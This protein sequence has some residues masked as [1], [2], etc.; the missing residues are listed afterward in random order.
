MFYSP[1]STS[2]MGAVIVA[3]GLKD[4][5]FESCR[6]VVLS[7]L[8]LFHIPLSLWVVC[9]KTGPSRRCNTSDFPK[10]KMFGVNRICKKMISLDIVDG[11]WP[12][13]EKLKIKPRR[14][15]IV[16]FYYNLST[17]KYKKLLWTN[18]LTFN[19]TSCFRNLQHFVLYKFFL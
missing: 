14:E 7:T 1:F 18:I 11:K 19:C 6:V 8:S 12:N 10:L 9:P 2:L 3:H 16:M 4:R 17:N 5:G 13:E 15:S